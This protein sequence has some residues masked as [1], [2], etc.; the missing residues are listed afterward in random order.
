MRNGSGGECK[1][2][3]MGIFFNCIL[4]HLF[5][6]FIESCIQSID[7]YYYYYWSA[8]LQCY[9]VGESANSSINA[10]EH[11]VHINGVHTSTALI[12][13]ATATRSPIT[14]LL[15]QISEAAHGAWHTELC[16]VCHG[17]WT[18]IRCEKWKMENV[19]IMQTTATVHTENV[20]I[21]RVW[22]IRSLTFQCPAASKG[23]K[24]VCHFIRTHIHLLG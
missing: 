8:V 12:S 13:I 15:E 20:I 21:M 22:I 10:M 19:N 2:H 18:R 17:P 1:R 23:Y 11:N 3:R 6:D 14:V 9:I 4:R 7:Y 5:V 24:G 16:N